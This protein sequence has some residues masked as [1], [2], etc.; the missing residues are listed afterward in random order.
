MLIV[1]AII[2]QEALHQGLGLGPQ[3]R[4]LPYVLPNALRFAVPGTML[5]AA[6]S[7]YGRMSASN[8]LV[9]I[10]SMGISPMAV[11]SPGFVLALI[12]S[13]A[14]VWVNDVAVSWGRQ[15]IQ[16][17]V[18]ES[19]E[20]I[21]YGMLKT[22]RTYNTSQFSIHVQSV[23]GRLL[24][25]PMLSF[26]ASENTPA[27][28]ILA[29]SAELR[30]NPDAGEL[31]VYLTN[32]TV[33]YGDKTS[34]V[35]PD[36]IERVIPLV[37]AARRGFGTEAPS[38]R[39]LREIPDAITQCKQDI[40]RMRQTL[41]AEA[42]L[43]M[44]TGDL[45]SLTDGSVKSLRI[46]LAHQHY[47]LHRLRTE[48]Y[49]RWANGFSCFFFVV[50]GAPLAIRMKNSDLMTTFGL[51]FLPILIV[52]YPLLM[53]AVDRAKDGALPPYTVWLGN[54][55]LFGIGIWFLRSVIRY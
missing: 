44:L 37:H 10:K 28:T 40:R 45:D 14:C 38:H 7:L 31:I 27:V 36:T 11:L 39:A 34:F 33:E 48:P 24:N 4:L 2:A 21:L 9:A 20:E 23:E 49:R 1:V 30:S 17:V 19:L 25:R 13:L 26:H 55:I 32:G 29:E 42:T 47:S 8:E 16:R 18:V 35:F 52:Y 46:Q 54:F 3:L 6:C 43:R 50:V 12:T 51:C 5:F 53:L 15:G 22:Q 41:A